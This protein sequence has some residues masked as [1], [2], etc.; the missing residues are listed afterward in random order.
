MG[1]SNVRETNE[2]MTQLGGTRLVQYE[3]LIKCRK[4]KTITQAVELTANDCAR[5]ALVQFKLEAVL[6]MTIQHIF[7]T[8]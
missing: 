8:P 2:L 6:W 3:R 4:A 5:Q 7:G 1:L